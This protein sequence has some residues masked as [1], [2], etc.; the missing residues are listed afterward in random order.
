MDLQ[1]PCVF[2][3][4]QNWPVVVVAS[5]CVTV[6]QKWAFE[7]LGDSMLYRLLCGPP[8]YNRHFFGA[9][10]DAIHEDD[11]DDAGSH[12]DSRIRGR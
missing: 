11:G 9:R 8:S 2:H 12:L 1:I 10:F 4:R 3:T 5:F 6:V 7:I